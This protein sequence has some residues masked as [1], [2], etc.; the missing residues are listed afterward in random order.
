MKPIKEFFIFGIKQA[1]ASIFGILLLLALIV[2]NY[3]DFIYI[4]RFD[5]IFLYAILIQIILI[6]LKLENKKEILLIAIFHILATGMELFKTSPSIESWTY[7]G[8]SIFMIATVPLFAGFLYSAVGSYIA[9]IWRIFNLS[10]KNYPK[11]VYTL[12]LAILAY[13]N[14]ISHHFLYDIRYILFAFSVLLFWK[15]K[16]TFTILKKRRSMSLLLGFSL[17]SFFIWIA[18]NIGTFSNVWLYP[19]QYS[20]WEI[21]SISK[22]GS[23]YLLMI[24]SFVLV[25]FIYR[26]NLKK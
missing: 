2:S 21:I 15:T 11:F 3:I 24:L 12:I 8:Q 26:K 9:R 17:V 23:W 25:S 16:V 4:S 6:L 10:F 14:F 18:E 20:S 22:I 7:Q 19:N 5:F 1:Y 13:T